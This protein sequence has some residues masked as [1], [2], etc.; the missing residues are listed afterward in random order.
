M[1]LAEHWHNQFVWTHAALNSN[2]AMEALVAESYNGMM[3]SVPRQE[4]QG[5]AGQTDEQV[6]RQSVGHIQV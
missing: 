4:G 6:D 2:V 5:K 3:D 1:G